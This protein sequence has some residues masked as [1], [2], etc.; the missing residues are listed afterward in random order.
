MPL[1]NTAGAAPIFFYPSFINGDSYA[2]GGITASTMQALVHRVYQMDPTAIWQGSAGASD[3]DSET[4]TCV[5]Y[6]GSAQVQ[7][8]ID[9]IIILNNNLK[10]FVVQYSTDGGSTWNNICGALNNN[11]A[12][13]VYFL[14]SPLTLP[15]GAQLQLLMSTTYPANQQ[16][17]IGNFIATQSIFQVSKPPTKFTANPMQ[18][19]KEV[20][21]ADGTHDHTYFFWSDN[22]CVLS[23][24]DFEF[25][26]L[27]ASDKALLDSLLAT[28]QPFII[29]PEPGDVPRAA[30]LAVFEPGSYLPAYMTTWKGAGYKIPAKFHQ[31]GYV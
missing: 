16:K 20:I 11:G 19:V 23:E 27:P 1:D 30:Y 21:L 29:Y 18:T 7:R 6:S 10:S 22:S 14:S 9:T 15:V 2:A 26:L 13:Y 12:D 5:L 17:F 28:A 4:I 3:S 31:E 25:D 24:L 8:V